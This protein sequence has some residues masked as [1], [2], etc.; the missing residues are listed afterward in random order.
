[1]RLIARYSVT[2]A[3]QA[4]VRVLPPREWSVVWFATL[5]SGHYRS[6]LRSG[7]NLRVDNLHEVVRR[8]NFPFPLAIGDNRRCFRAVHSSVE[9]VADRTV[10]RPY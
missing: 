7:L 8:A 6:R 1:M 4:S 5:P 10:R 9:K 3:L 2:T